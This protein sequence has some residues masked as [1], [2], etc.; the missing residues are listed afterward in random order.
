MAVGAQKANQTDERQNYAFYDNI[1]SRGKN[2]KQTLMQKWSLIQNQPLLKQFI[3][4]LLLYHTKK[5]NRHSKICSSGQ[6]FRGSCAATAKPHRGACVG[7]SMTFTV[8]VIFQ[9]G[10]VPYVTSRTLFKYTILR[11]QNLIIC[12]ISQLLHRSNDTS[13]LYL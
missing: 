1:T 8:S 4:R 13:W 12:V 5:E 9:T 6:N 11:V 7:L 10:P 2:L 3:E